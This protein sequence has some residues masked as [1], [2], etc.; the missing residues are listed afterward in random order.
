[1]TSM[2]SASL[3]PE[4]LACDI[5][6][7]LFKGQLRDYQ[8]TGFQ[9]LVKRCFLGE[10]VILA[11]AMGLGKTIQILAYLAWT[12]EHV[13]GS[14]L[15]ICPLSTLGNWLLETNRFLPDVPVVRY[16]GTAEEKR[17]L[18]KR[19]RKLVSAAQKY[20]RVKAQWTEYSENPTGPE[21][22]PLPSVAYFP[23]VLASYEVAVRDANYLLRV[24]WKDM[25]MDEAHRLKNEKVRRTLARG[26]I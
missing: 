22:P 25:I 3:S 13:D 10:S 20:N 11:D 15:I 1:M 24:Q 26:G 18:D 23:I 14:T 6:P 5:P 8:M 9:W 7:A 19:I 12:K 4:Q 21:P 2:E 16:Y 17:E